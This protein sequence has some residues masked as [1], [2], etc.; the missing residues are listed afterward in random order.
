MARA[1]R[2]PLFF[3]VLL[4]GAALLVAL[5]ARPIASALFIAAVLAGVMYPVQRR[6]AVMLHR[7][8]I[9]AGVIVA[10]VLLVLLVPIAV[11]S[12]EAVT[13]VTQGVRYVQDTLKSEGVTGL[14]QKLPPSLRSLATSAVDR[15]SPDPDATAGKAVDQLQVEGG[16]AAAMVG[17][18]AMATGSMIFQAV[19]MLIALYFLLLDGPR[20]IQWLE[21]TVPLRTGEMREL[22]SEFRA[23]SRSVIVSSLITAGAQALAALV[24]YLIARVPNPIFFAGITFFMALIP[25]IGAGIVCL[26]AA[27]LLFFTGHPIA[28]LFLA[29]W[30]VVVVGLIDNIVKPYLVSEDMEMHGALVFFSMIGG[31]AAFGAVGL[32][33]GPLVANLFLTLTSMYRRSYKPVS[34][35]PASQER[36]A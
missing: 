23:V 36:S 21:R 27:T 26:A 12:T 5:M 19:M 6:L 1:E 18:V 16:K 31:V 17:A 15:I 10:G 35:R 29:I 33:I 2:S 30:G 34:S 7:R 25:V 8:G 13:E 9:A 11:L 28:A 4:T 24:G 22:L 3:Y 32:L 14:I 20:L